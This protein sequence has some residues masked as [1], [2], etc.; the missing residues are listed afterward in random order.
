MGQREPPLQFQFLLLTLLVLQF[1]SNPEKVIINYPSVQFSRST[2][3]AAWV[4]G[5]VLMFEWSVFPE[6]WRA[7]ELWLRKRYADHSVHAA[8]HCSNSP[9]PPA[10]NWLGA[11]IVPGQ[12]DH[13]WSWARKFRERARYVTEWSYCHDQHSV[14][15]CFPLANLLAFVGRNCWVDRSLLSFGGRQWELSHS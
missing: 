1:P 14:C 10:D 6:K 15:R 4:I 11:S 13:Q 7:S 8:F 12:A 3:R 2:H 9:T 5:L